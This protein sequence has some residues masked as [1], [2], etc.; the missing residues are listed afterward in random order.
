MSTVTPDFEAARCVRYRYRY[1]ACRRCSDACPHAA[2]VLRDDGVALDAAKCRNCA[3]CT[4]ACPTAAWVPGNL[5][6]IDLLKQAL[7]K[8]AP[9]TIACAPAGLAADA[10][11]PCLGALDGA[12]L[13]YLGK[14]G[15]EATL[16][17]AAHC[18]RCEQGHVGAACLAA[19]VRARDAL[20]EACTGETWA[21]LTV[22]DETA[23][24]G[25]DTFRPGR[26]GLFRRL[27][28]RGVAEAE[29][30]LAAPVELPIIDKAIRPG[31]WLV[32]EMRELLQIVCRRG[33]GEP[34]RL[35]A[36]PELRVASLRLEPGCS[37]C[38]AC[39]RACPTGAL[40]IRETTSAWHLMFFVDRCVGCGVCGE[41]CQ[42]QALRQSDTVDATPGGA[43]TALKV[44]AKQRCSRCDRYFVSAAP[45]ASCPVCR[46]DD[47]AFDRIF[48]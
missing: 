4:A 13:A 36:L 15:I 9:F 29:K 14:R 12:L 17:G 38:E 19:Q 22:G 44:L 23:A 32:P 45:Q 30:A 31:P 39:V 16:A 27:I 21:R 25:E 10:L 20:E 11:V 6:R 37:N 26:R 46:D 8:N 7:A 3:L 47:A 35:P 28:G 24:A 2:L 42:P 18:E 1:S 41:V 40:Q 48:G 5:A 34:C 33:D 43:G